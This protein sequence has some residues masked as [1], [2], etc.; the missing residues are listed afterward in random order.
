[1]AD[2]ETT[3]VPVP[4]EVPEAPV[5]EEKVEEPEP[6]FYEFDLTFAEKPV[7]L[8]DK[9]GK[10]QNY[11]LRE[12]DGAGRDTFLS[13]MAKRSPTRV[14]PTT[15][16]P[17]GEARIVDPAGLEPRLIALCLFDEKNKSVPEATIKSW[18]GHVQEGLFAAAA[19]LNGIDKGAEAR[20]KK[21]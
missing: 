19:R 8:K 13:L 16:K 3:P 20:A 2:E 5:V 21:P 12:L 1:M 10:I 4:D 11:T 6:D 7:K 18:P 9:E 17:T 14:D 15:G